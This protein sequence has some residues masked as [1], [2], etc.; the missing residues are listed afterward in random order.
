M[1]KKV[2]SRNAL[3]A[4]LVN[5]KHTINDDKMQDKLAPGEKD[6]VLNKVNQIESWM[7]S[8]SSAETEGYEAKQK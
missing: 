1:R 5:I 8:N 4:Y 6:Q 7:S 2:E 3:E